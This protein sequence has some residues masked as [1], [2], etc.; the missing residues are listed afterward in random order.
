MRNFLIVVTIF[1]ISVIGISAISWPLYAS[2]PLQ[3][4]IPFN[5]FLKWL[6]ILCVAILTVAVLKHRGCLT[7]NQVGFYPPKRSPLSLLSMGVITGFLMLSS[8]GVVFY[9]LD[10][11]MFTSDNSLLSSISKLI[12]S[13]LPTALLISLIEETYFRGIQC[14]QLIKEKRVA[15][16]IVLPAAFYMCIHFLNPQ[17]VIIAQNPEW[18]YGITLMLSAP[19][20]ICHTN[21][22]VGMGATLFLAGIFLSL[23]RLLGKHLIVCIGIHAG[24]ITGIKL[25]KYLTD[26]NRNSDLAFL[27][28]GHDHFIGI[29]AALWLII[30]CVLLGKMLARDIKSGYQN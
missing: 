4:W 17:K 16:A 7:W 1:I 5:K 24:W 14:S 19:S 28:E 15:A 2:L 30:P 3:Q 12:L 13:I 23:A 8:L 29:L 25:T 18:F 20:Q 26:F 22:C 21:D 10:I 6:T 9:L 27:A 11:R